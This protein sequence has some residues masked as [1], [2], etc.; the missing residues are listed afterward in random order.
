MLN[1]GKAILIT[2]IL[3]FECVTGT[4]IIKKFV[5]KKMIARMVDSSICNMHFNGRLRKVIRFKRAHHM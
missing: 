3:L 5:K 2:L 1:A 4:Q